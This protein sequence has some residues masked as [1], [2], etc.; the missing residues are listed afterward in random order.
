MKVAGIRKGFQFLLGRLE[1]AMRT[2][3]GRY[4]FWFQF[5]LGRLET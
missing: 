2:A 5:L 4:V 3:D 1:T